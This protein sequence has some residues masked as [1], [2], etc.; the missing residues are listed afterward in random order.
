M[1]RKA[2]PLWRNSSN[3]SASDACFA[4][5]IDTTPEGDVGQ[6]LLDAVGY[7]VIAI[8]VFDLSKYILEEDVTALPRCGTPHRH[9]AATRSS[10]PSSALPCSLRAWLQFSK[11]EEER[12]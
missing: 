6:S 4:R 5:A 8:E 10:S 7:A 1:W 12:R 3:R 2:L 9:G 11:P